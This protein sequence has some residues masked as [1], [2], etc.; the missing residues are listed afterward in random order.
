[1]QLTSE[2]YHSLEADAEF[3]SV[4]QFQSWLT[5]P[6]REA[7]RQRGDYEP[8]S[9]RAFILGS[10]VDAALTEPS[11]V[12]EAFKDEHADDLFK[13]N[14]TPYAEIAQADAMIATLRKQPEATYLLGHRGNGETQVIVTG[15]IDGVAWKGKIDVLLADDALFVDLK[16]A[17]SFYRWIEVVDPAKGL[18]NQKVAWYEVYNYWRQISV[19]AELLRQSRGVDAT[20]VILGVTKEDPPD[21][22]VWLFENTTRLDSELRQIGYLLPEVLE[23]KEADAPRCGHCDWCRRTKT[24]A[25]HT[26]KNEVALRA[27]PRWYRDRQ[28]GG[29]A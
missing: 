6:A 27:L 16:T 11:E 24:L 22:D 18:R 17:A 21:A 20:G 2:N 14:G 23:W 1:M 12:F 10:Y 19:Y 26:A 8:P 9:K 15:E 13:K 4:H 5:C 29:E 25:I 3:M 28:I 7:A